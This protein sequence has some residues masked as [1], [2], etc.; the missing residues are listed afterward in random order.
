M[1]RRNAAVQSV[2]PSA[3]APKRLRSK[4]RFGKRG[5]LMRFRIEGITVSQGFSAA[6]R[7]GGIA[8]ARPANERVLMNSRRVVIQED[9]PAKT[10]RRKGSHRRKAYLCAFASLREKTFSFHLGYSF[11]SS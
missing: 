5:G 7:R 9:S 4:V 1:A 10:Q 11:F 3:F 6:S 8:S 2:R